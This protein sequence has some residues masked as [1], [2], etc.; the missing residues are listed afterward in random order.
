MKTLSRIRSWFKAMT[1]RSR[2]DVE[3]QSELEFHMES[4]AADLMRTGLSRDEARRRARLELGSV[5]ARKEECRESLGLRLWDDLLAD[6]RY[7]LRMLRKAPGF[8]IIAIVSLA[9]GIGA[10]TIIFSLAK[11]A[12]LDELA[13]SHPEQLRLL[14]LYIQ[15]NDNLISSVWG[16]FN[17]GPGGTTETTSFTYPVYQLLRQQNRSLANI[18]AFKELGTYDRLTATIDGHAQPVT[19]QLVSGDYYRGLGVEAAVGRSIQS[20]DDAVAGEGAVAV[21]SDG[22]WA[23][24]F[25]RSPAAIGKT[26]ALN[27]T[28]VTIIGVNPPSFTGAASVQQSPD[29]FVPLSMQPVILPQRSGSLLE[30]KKL[31]WVQVMGRTKPGVSDPAALAALSVG[32]DQAIRAT[33]P[34]PKDAKMAQLTLPSGSRGLN[35]TGRDWGTRLY[36]LLTLS[37]LVLLLACANIAN[38]LLARSAAR[39][40]EVS[41]RMALGAGRGRILRQVFTESLLLSL[42]GGATGLIFGYFGRNVIPR[43]LSSSWR[44]PVVDGRFDWGVMVFTAGV[45]LLTGLL[46][47]LAPALQ[48]TRGDVN[49]G[50]KDG[51]AAA[52]KRRQ[53]LAGKAIVIFQVSL[54]M[55]LVVGAGLFVRTLVNLTE[56]DPGFRPQHVLLFHIQPP[57]SRYPVAK[58]IA[59]DHQIE[60]KLAALPGLDSV[61][62]STL[63][64]LA[65]DV[66]MTDFVPDGKSRDANPN[67][68]EDVNFVGRGFLATM[69]IP[70]LSGRDFT[71]DDTETSP[72]VAVINKTLAR[73]Y[74]PNSDPVGKYFTSDKKRILIVGIC[75]D[76]KYSDV[77]DDIPPQF[78]LP[79]RQSADQPDLQG[80]V[81]FELRLKTTPESVL[82]AIRAAIASIDKDLPLIDVR[83]QTE[84]IDATLSQERL[85]AMLTGAFGVL[86][87][88]L[89]CIGIY[90]IMAYTVARR[91]NEIGIRIALGAR[92]DQVLRMVLSEASWLAVIGIAIGLGCAIWLTRFLG[93]LLYGLKPSDPLTLIGAAALLLGTALAAGW[94]PAWRASQVQPMEALRHE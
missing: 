53:G 12:L 35:E 50:L 3:I 5:A 60:E 8:T 65:N 51:S 67:T 73:K 90:G 39:Q 64:L 37:G 85:F 42:L 59:L 19:G 31:W 17:P 32:L 48:S 52:T 94:I 16:S 78:Y 27:L 10:N 44:P 89:A 72:P 80:G 30:D 14:T 55:L 26:I 88:V 46:F 36:V 54:S 69:G 34:I 7:G 23:R 70:L 9:L 93:A 56:T 91:T 2:L 84:Q 1:H 86:A 11:A 71:A 18:F 82:P 63:P 43:L 15:H 75:A 28:P 77:R 41:V 62:V 4:Y 38:L 87:L 68:A 61:S 81:T 24:A 33:M 92:T 45:S 83:S 76:A 21:I 13:V 47:G 22:F 49:N 74:F 29:V 79:Y 66:S 58:S 20:A 6:I 25:G 57:L 40:R